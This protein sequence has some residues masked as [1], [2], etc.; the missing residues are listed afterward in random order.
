MTYILRLKFPNSS[1]AQIKIPWL[2]YVAACKKSLYQVF[3][4]FTLTTET[5]LMLMYPFFLHKILF[6]ISNLQY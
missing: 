2:F 5:L 6:L 4:N 1:P 3:T